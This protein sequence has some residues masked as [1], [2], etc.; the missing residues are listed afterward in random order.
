VSEITERGN[1]D[2]QLT[3]TIEKRLR[4]LC[5]D[6]DSSIPLPILAQSISSLYSGLMM[7]WFTKFK[8]QS[9]DIRQF[10][11][12]MHRMT[13]ALIFEAIGKSTT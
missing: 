11:I 8:F 9:S 3:V 1:I 6:G 13:R 4:S 7:S 2:L 5:N 10:A 12:N